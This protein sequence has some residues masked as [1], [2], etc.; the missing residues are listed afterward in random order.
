M[1]IY[2]PCPREKEKPKQNGSRGKVTFRIKPHICLR[3]LEGSNKTC[4]HQDPENPQRLEKTVFECG[5]Q[6]YKS[7]VAYFRGRG[8]CI[9]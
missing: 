1:Y 2:T 9:Q 6:K 3:C 8:L 5:L 7:A 4:A